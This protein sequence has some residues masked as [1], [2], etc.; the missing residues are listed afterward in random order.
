MSRYVGNR[1]ADPP[2]D[3]IVQH[4]VLKY[5][6]DESHAAYSGS[7]L[8]SKLEQQDEASRFQIYIVGHGADKVALLS[9]QGEDPAPESGKR[10]E[11]LFPA[12]ETKTP[13]AIAVDLYRAIPTGTE[14]RVK[15]GMCFG[16][17][18]LPAQVTRVV[19]DEGRT[20]F[21][22]STVKP[23]RQ[24]Q[25]LTIV[26]GVKQRQFFPADD[27][28]DQLR[29]TFAN[30]VARSLHTLMEN[31]S[32]DKKKD[33][34]RVYVGGFDATVYW[35]EGGPINKHAPRARVTIGGR[36]DYERIQREYYSPSENG[37]LV[38]RNRL[39]GG[40]WAFKSRFPTYYCYF[41]VK[42]KITAAPRDAVS[43]SE[44]LPP[45]GTP[46]DGWSFLM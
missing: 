38:R 41:P 32:E 45:Q 16:G 11:D 17:T 44:L 10:R 40:F 4:L 43:G 15:L 20:K 13:H 36:T 23:D 34:S 37:T 39:P 24:A 26:H 2:M 31:A 30:A 9:N 18:P 28:K 7:E 42:L 3:E 27:T 46:D 12:E 22:S 14:V 8:K 1:L 5:K 29:A 19:E 21:T 35:P 25:K 33:L 6:L